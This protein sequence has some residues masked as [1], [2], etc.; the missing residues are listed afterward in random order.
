[1]FAALLVA[2]VALAATARAAEVRSPD[3]SLVV[4]VEVD[5]NGAPRYAVARNGSALMPAGFLGLRFQSQAAFDDGF[6]VAGTA[7]AS[8]DQTWEQP[9]GERRFVR[10]RHNELL[11]NFESSH[12]AGAQVRAAWSGSSTTASASATRCRSSRATTRSTSPRN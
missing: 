4:S 9:W 3:G 10:D 12:G 2:L 11:V 1:M 5:E 8:H 7:T 6:R